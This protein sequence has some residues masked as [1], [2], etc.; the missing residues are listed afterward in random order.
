MS[1]RLNNKKYYKEIES[2][3]FIDEIMLNKDYLAKNKNSNSSLHKKLANKSNSI[4]SN[5][6]LNAL[7][8]FFNRYE[9]DDR[10]ILSKKKFIISFEEL[11]YLI[12]ESIITQQKIDNII[13]NKNNSHNKIM[14]NIHIQKINQKYINDLSYNIF[15]FDKIDI[16]YN[17]NMK[18]KKKSNSNISPNNLNFHHNTKKKKQYNNQASISPNN[19]KKEINSIFENIY[20]EVFINGNN[21]LNNNGNKRNIKLKKKSEL[22]KTKYNNND[23]RNK[24][25]IIRRDISISNYNKKSKNKNGNKRLNNT[26]ITNNIS[27]N[28]SYNNNN[29]NISKNYSTQNLKNLSSFSSNKKSITNANTNSTKKIKRS[30]TFKNINKNKNKKKGKDELKYSDIF[31][32]CENINQLK[33]SANKKILSRSN[34]CFSNDIN[35]NE[36][37]VKKSLRSVGF[38]DIYNNNN[39]SDIIGYEELKFHTGIKK[40]IVSITHKPSNL[41]NKLLISGQK[42]IDDFKEMNE[43]TKKKSV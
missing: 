41:A 5:I 4:Q 23:Q 19:I 2:E 39:Y 18:K 25:A 36:S 21:P 3:I 30:K 26:I 8:E 11:I 22:S 16:G 17:F 33:S 20:K 9:L 12:R 24:S 42:Y 32:A 29:I 27:N 15:S 13:Y 37:F 28:I 43:S 6:L 38:K 7:Q 10:K 1:D 35:D 31:A 34:N 40:I 14:N